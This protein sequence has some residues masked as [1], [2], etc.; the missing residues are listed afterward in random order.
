MACGPSPGDSP[1]LNAAADGTLVIGTHFDEPGL[2]FRT[3]TGKM[4]GFDVDVAR[5]VAGQLG[6]D[7]IEWKDVSSGDREK[8]IRNGT[9]DMV[10]GTYSITDD[11]KKLV[12]FAGPYYVAGQDLLVRKRDKSITGPQSLNGKKLCSVRGTTSAK[13]VKEKFAKHT[14]LVEYDRYS[15]CVN[16][17]LTNLVDAVTTDNT[18][19]AGYVE[20]FPELLRLVGKPFTKERYGVGFTKG[21]TKGQQEVGAALRKMVSSGAWQQALRTNL[22]ESGIPIPSAPHIVLG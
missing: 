12:S 1:L 21:D 16:A 9:V 17:M 15:G 4:T 6:A 18:I 5:Y 20:E 19:L 3:V 11:R 14:Q 10:V 8:V 7:H 13:A 2:G 22:G